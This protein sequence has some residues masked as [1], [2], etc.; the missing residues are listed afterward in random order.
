MELN[1]GEVVMLVRLVTLMPDGVM[2]MNEQDELTMMESH[3]DFE[4][5]TDKILAESNRD[6]VVALVRKLNGDDDGRN[7]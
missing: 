4:S 3:P 7:A 5:L 2:V 1:S 6:D